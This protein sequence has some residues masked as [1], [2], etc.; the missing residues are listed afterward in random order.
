MS[1]QSGLAIRG[2]TVGFGAGD[3]I[4]QVLHGVDL[5][6]PAG[7]TLGLVGESGCGKSVTML[8]VMR[9]L[10][11]RA[12]VTGRIRMG[13]LDLLSLEERE[14]ET[15]RG[16]RLAMIFQDPTSSLNPVHPIG[17]QLGEALCLHRGLTGA[18]ARREAARL[19]DRVG[20]PAARQRLGDYPHQLSG[21]MN[22]RVMIA[23][24]L[25][26]EPDI[27]IAD[28]PTTA[29]D[30]TIQAQILD[31]LRGLQ[32]ERRMSIVL[33]THD[34]GVVA[35]MADEVAV[36]YCGRVVERASVE[37]LFH[38][39]AHPYTQGLLG[40]LPRMGTGDRSLTPIPGAVPVPGSLPP[41]CAFRPRCPV[42]M[43]ACASSLPAFVKLSARHGV[44]CRMEVLAAA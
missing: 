32:Q 40:S 12:H 10:G 37:S 15:V 29:L 20:I 16:R 36:M 27:L 9:L 24:A 11:P 4:V 41:G 18:A 42:A 39:P 19:L 7:R 25:A 34:L 21:G 8:A 5:D 1:E 44:A 13:S 17:L 43:T 38:R 14:M 30:V 31:L 6:I 23:M 33:I 2:L 26:G 3:A 35:E 22:Q 28:E